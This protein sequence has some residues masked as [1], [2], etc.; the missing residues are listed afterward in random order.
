MPSNG[1]NPP[2]IAPLALIAPMAPITPIALLALLALL[3]FPQYAWGDYVSG[4]RAFDHGRYSLAAEILNPLAE[5][6]NAFAQYAM[7]FMFEKGKGLPQDFFM[8]VR[9]YRKAAKQGFAEA[10]HNLGTLYGHGQGGAQGFRPGRVLLPARGHAGS[11]PGPIKDR[12]HVPARNGCA[13]GFRQGG[14]LVPRGRREWRPGGA[15][16]SGPDVSKEKWNR[17]Q[18]IE[19]LLLVFPGRQAFP[20]K[21]RQ[22]GREPSRSVRQ[23]AFRQGTGGAE[24]QTERLEAPVAGSGMKIGKYFSENHGFPPPS[25][26][27]WVLAGL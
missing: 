25:T 26:G 3:V 5:G 19:G 21:N 24:R 22:T 7:G 1:N 11:C 9:W 15:I 12:L 18:S 10:Q 20:W 8:A 27:E 23:K 6:G 16:Q 2:P 4:K 17:E 14:L 13:Q